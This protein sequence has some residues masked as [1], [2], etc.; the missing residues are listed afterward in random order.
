MILLR[1]PTLTLSFLFTIVSLGLTLSTISIDQ[2][3]FVVPLRVLIIAPPLNC[4]L[5]FLFSVTWIERLFRLSFVPTISLF[6]IFLSAL[7][8]TI[9][10]AFYML[11]STIVVLNFVFYLTLTVVLFALLI[12]ILICYCYGSSW[13]HRFRKRMTPEENKNPSRENL[14]PLK[15]DS[16]QLDENLTLFMSKLPGRRIRNDVRRIE[17]DL[18][19][20]QVDLIVTLNEPKEFSTMNFDENRPYNLQVYSDFIRR[21]NIQHFVYSIRDRFIPKSISEYMTFLCQVLVDAETKN[22]KK[23]LVHCM[24]GMGRTGLTV[25]C[26]D[27]LKSSFDENLQQDENCIERIFHYPFLFE[28]SCRVCRSIARVRKA[29]KGTIHNPLQI[30]FAHE[31]NARLRSKPY[32]DQIKKNLQL[33]RSSAHNLTV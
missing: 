33:I 27:L 32:I 13:V 4:L 24:G 28:N 7:S 8:L 25:V 14:A 5:I 26:L 9:I 10:C 21:A 19:Q 16:F 20:I 23:I 31:F 18:E 17:D 1:S 29:R 15:I 2:N 12:L 3:S 22:H 30:I 6:L 11:V